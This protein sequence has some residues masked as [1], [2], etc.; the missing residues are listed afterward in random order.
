[1]PR[2][3][4]KGSI[5]FGLVSF[6]IKLY[7]ATEPKQIEFNNLHSLC[8]TKLEQRRWC[9]KCKREV[10]WKEVEKGFKI[11]KD[12][13]IIL[14]KEEIERVKLPTTKTIEVVYFVDTSQIDPIHYEKSYYVVPTEAG[15][16]PYSLFVEALRIANKAAIGKVVFRNKE[17]IVALRAFKKG[18]VMHTLFY[19]EEI[20]DINELPELKGLV[21]IGKEE[22]GLAKALIESLAKHEFK[23]GEFKDK[24]TEALKQLIKAKAEGKEFRVR[25]EKRVEEAK[26]LMKALKAS[27]EIAKKRKR[28]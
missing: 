21:V 17:H 23:A 26:S 24:Y 5:T 13:W 8:H 4:F 15:I 14:S 2:A 10:P 20:R 28:T 27:V 9:P 25:E 3:V 7:T 22:L 19:K 16:K 1:M 18:I 12:R 6:P 11:A